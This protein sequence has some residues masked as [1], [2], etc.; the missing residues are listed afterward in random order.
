MASMLF[1]I[2]VVVGVFVILLNVVM[3]YAAITT[4]GE[5]DHRPPALADAV[6]D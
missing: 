2:M 5:D 1:S 3:V 4:V 6:D